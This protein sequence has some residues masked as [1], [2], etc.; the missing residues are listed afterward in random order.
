MRPRVPPWACEFTPQ[1]VVAVGST[2]DSL[3]PRTAFTELPDGVLAPGVQEKNITNVDLL[4]KHLEETLRKVGFKGSE[5]SIVIPDETARITV[6]HTDTLPSDR[7]ERQ[8]FI[9]WK[10]RKTVPFDADSSQLSYTVIDSTKSGFHLLVAMSPSAIVRQYEEVL[11][12][13]DIHAGLVMPSTLAAMNLLG[14]SSTDI[15]FVKYRPGAVSTS[16]VMGRQLRFYRRVDGESLYEAAFPTV[17]Y[18]QD[19]LS[20]TGLRNAV[21]CGYGALLGDRIAE[22]QSRMGIEVNRL[23]PASVQDLFKPAIGVTQLA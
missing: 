21:V 12:G 22:L 19:R 1:H 23:G 6:L 17:M 14:A 2:R 8:S 16:I 5:M 20:G 7:T 13:L 15:L 4:R 9:R 11:E 10:L 3:A 18:Y